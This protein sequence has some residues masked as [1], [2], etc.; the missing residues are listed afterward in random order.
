MAKVVEGSSSKTKIKKKGR[1]S[2]KRSYN[3]K[4]KNYNK[5]YKGQG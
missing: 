5:P 3:K 2:K 1:Y 4:S